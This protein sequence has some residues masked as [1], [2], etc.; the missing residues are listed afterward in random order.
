MLEL[1]LNSSLAMM[2]AP[3]NTSQGTCIKFNQSDPFH[4]G[5]RY[6]GIPLNLLTNL[7]G[8]IILLI[9]F[10]LIRKN[11]VR[12]MGLKLASDTI[13][14]MDAVT[15]QWTQIF[16]RRDKSCIE[17]AED[18]LEQAESAETLCCKDESDK[19]EVDQI[20][21]AQT[22]TEDESMSIQSSSSNMRKNTKIML[23]LKEKKLVGLMGSDAVQYLRFQK[24]ILIYIFLTT[25]VSLGVILPLNFQGTQL[26]MLQI[27]AI[28]H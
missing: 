4:I 23:T 26:G 18:T 27:L 28:Q 25:M 15:T 17:T 2:T 1:E 8:W 13:D 16:F 11:A 14:S 7:I 21:V 9:L 3:N 22:D 19:A 12:K 6:G 20:K 10:V 24:Y 5:D